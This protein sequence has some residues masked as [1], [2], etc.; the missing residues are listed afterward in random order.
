MADWWYRSAGFSSCMNLWRFKFLIRVRRF[1]DTTTRQQ[2]K[3]HDKFA[4]IHQLFELVDKCKTNFS[5][6]DYLTIDK[7]LESFRSRCGF[8]YYIKNKPAKNGVKIF[9]MIFA[10]TFYTINIEVCNGKQPEGPYCIKALNTEL[11]TLY[12]L[13]YQDL[14]SRLVVQGETLPLTTGIPKPP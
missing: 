1:D 12:W 3:E 10:K 7:M 14:S 6:S 13:L 4:P 11:K 8:K 2:Q 5:V 9:I